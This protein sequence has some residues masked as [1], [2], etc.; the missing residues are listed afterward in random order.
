[1][2]KQFYTGLF[3]ALACAASPAA[4]AAPLYHLVQS[5][6]L[7][8]AAKW[9][10]LHFDAP[11]DRVYIS[12]GTELTVVDARTGAIAGH[13]TGLAGSHGV[14]IDTAA[15][16]GFADSSQNRMISVFSLKTLAV[17]ARVP[18]LE[19]ADGMVF[20]KP[21]GQVF[22]VGGDA[23]A[24]LVLDGATQRQVATIALGGSPESQVSDQ[25]G[26][27][28]VDLKNKNELARISTR[29]GA[30]TGRWKLPG[31]EGPTGLAID[32]ARH[33]LFATCQNARMAVVNGDTGA[34]LANL[35]IGKGTDSAAFDPVRKLA[36]SSNRDGTLSVIAEVSAT[37][38]AVLP[39]VET[40]PG[41]RTMAVDPATGRLF[42]VSATVQSA[43][44]PKQP[45]AAPFYTFL[46][47]S[48]RLLIYAPNA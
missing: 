20:D 7:G 28:F 26:A 22:T 27:I 32:R 35:P 31:C 42:L 24:D 5:V 8:G 37:K 17:S 34:M 36:F 4:Q 45:N 9:D 29:T 39:P 11:S 44:P 10:Y 13:V 43:T 1:M 47:G 19:D 14:A 25:A 16:L 6:P 3:A 46:P 12:H 33:V 18:A 30:I 2:K 23:S 40:E 41:A 21:S 38:F 48:V 15:G